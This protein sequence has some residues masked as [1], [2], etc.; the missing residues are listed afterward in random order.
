MIE[1]LK[2]CFQLNQKCKLQT[3][4]EKCQFNLQSTVSGGVTYSL[5]LL[6]TDSA[7]NLNFIALLTGTYCY[8]VKRV[9]KETP[10]FH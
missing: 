3:L 2:K 1:V 10:T 5:M 7:H 9:V 8:W 6:Y 4:V